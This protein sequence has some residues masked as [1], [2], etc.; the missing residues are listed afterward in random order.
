MTEELI[1]NYSRVSTDDQNIKQQNDLLIQQCRNN[2]QKY[3]SYTDFDV[4]GKVPIFDRESGK[5]LVQDLIKGNVQGIRVTKWDRITRNLQHGLDWL[6]FWEEHKFKWYSIYEGE[7]LGT[8]DQKF[9]FKL[10]CLLAEFELDQ[11]EWRRNIGIERAKAEGKYK[12]RVKG[13]KNKNTIQVE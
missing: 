8:P 5:K 10:K 4:S 12:G 6:K 11:L 1:G 13:S 3:R 9:S 2:N 7:F